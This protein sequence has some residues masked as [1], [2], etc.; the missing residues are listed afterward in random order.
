MFSTQWKPDRTSPVPLY[1]QI[2]EFIRQKIK[3]G[4]WP[5]GSKIPTERQLAALLGVNRSTV[6]TAYS[7]LAADGLIEG[8]SG[9][10]TRVIN[11]TWA[12]MAATALPDWD[13]YTRSG[14]FRPNLPI[15]QEINRTESDDQLIHLGTAGPPPELYPRELLQSILGELPE[16]MGSLGYE[17]PKGLYHLREQVCAYARSR[18]IEATPSSVLIVSG[19]LQAFQLI[20]IGLLKKGAAVLAESPSFIQSLFVFQSAGTRLVGLPLDE[21]GLQTEALADK[22]NE[23]K[24]GILY[25]NPCFHNPTGIVMSERRREQLLAIC[26]E[27]QL[28]IIEDDVYRDLWLDEQPPLPLKARD[29]HGLI[30][31]LGSMSKCFG[32]GLRIGWLIGPEP[33]INRLADLKMQL[34]Y[35]ASSLSQW[36]VAECLKGGWY[37]LHLQRTREL[38]RKRREAAVQALQRYMNG[39]ATWTLPGGGFFIWLRLQKPLSLRLLFEHAL[40]GGVLLYPGNI[41]E[42]SD[43][44]HIRLSYGYASGEQLEEGIK[45]LAGFIRKLT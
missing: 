23:W 26:Q 3:T 38:L 15:V 42:H 19:A 39:L 2:T 35:G 43:Q 4:E 7:E 21:E 16:K 14:L 13:T 40:S 24:G 29:Q 44:R 32:P 33:V 27:R 12:V 41:Y 31:Y 11:N 8:N 10:G 34:D 22:A 36:L 5:L 1:R 28:P 18:G 6:V 9:S 20:S 37:E 45:R 17:E 25:T 30:L